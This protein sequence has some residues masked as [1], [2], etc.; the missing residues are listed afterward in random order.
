MRDYLGLYK[1][2]QYHLPDFRRGSQIR[3][4]KGI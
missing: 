2:E 1:G 4:K 3:G